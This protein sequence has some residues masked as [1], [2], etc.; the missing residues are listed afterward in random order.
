MLEGSIKKVISEKGYGFITTP[1]GDVFFHCSALKDINFADVKVGDKVTFEE[2]QGP[3]G[4][5]AKDVRVIA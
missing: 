5:R 3:K 2:D 1:R 4:P